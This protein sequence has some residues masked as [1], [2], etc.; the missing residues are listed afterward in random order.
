M[1]HFRAIQK[2]SKK[3]S[4]KFLIENCNYQLPMKKLKIVYSKQ[5][6]PGTT[7]T[8]NNSAEFLIQRSYRFS[9]L[10]SELVLVSN[11]CKKDQLSVFEKRVSDCDEIW[12]PHTR[13]V[14]STFDWDNSPDLVTPLG[15]DQ[16]APEVT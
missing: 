15:P 2:I 11:L 14:N 10:M 5:K 4:K 8:K 16:L 3:V 7:W 1:G 12:H 9:L 6:R 13:G